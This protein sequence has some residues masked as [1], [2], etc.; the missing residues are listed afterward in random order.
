MA[1][2]L[3]LSLSACASVERLPTLDRQFY[4]NLESDS[5]K[6]AFLHLKESERQGFLEQKGLWQKWT[7][8]SAGERDSVKTKDVQVG[9]KE[10]A[11]H[12]AWGPPAKVRN[13]E[14]RGRSI[15]YETFVRCTSG[16]KIGRYVGSNLDCDGTSAETELAIENG[17]VTQ[18]KH[19]D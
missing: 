7:E 1:A 2:L 12:M 8:L 4:Y 18:I 16:P 3:L 14:A 6:D 5:D 13:A 11:A 15:R 17:L 19:L 9:H 10:F